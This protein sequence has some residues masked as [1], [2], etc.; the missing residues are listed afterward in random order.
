MDDNKSSYKNPAVIT[1]IIEEINKHFGDFSVVRGN[2]KTFLGIK[3][4]RKNNVIH[5][6]IF[7]KLR[8]FMK[9]FGEDVSTPVLSPATKTLFEV[10]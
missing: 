7:E 8:E 5:I 3:I 10:R 2:K 9:M 6:G 4:E 1:N